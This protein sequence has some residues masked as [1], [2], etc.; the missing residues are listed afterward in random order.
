MIYLSIN[1]FPSIEIMNS[2]AE[3]GLIRV[4]VGIENNNKNVLK[5]FNKPILRSFDDIV[6]SIFTPLHISYHIGYMVFYP[7]VTF[8][9]IKESIN[10]LQ[11]I[12]KIHRVGVIL[13]KMRLIP[14]TK[15]C[16]KYANNEITGID[17]A[18]SY[19]FVDPKV[20]TLFVCL[21]LVFEYFLKS[22]HTKAEAMCTGYTLLDAFC[23]RDDIK[24]YTRRDFSEARLRH[25]ASI[26]DYQKCL[27]YFFDIFLEQ[28]EKQTIDEKSIFNCS[29]IEQF[30]VEFMKNVA[31]L[32]IAWTVLLN[33]VSD[34]YNFDAEKIVTWGEE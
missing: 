18:Y 15:M 3:A 20:N 5:T 17:G 4:F 26:G 25:E 28:I 32:Q 29:F 8:F 2:L 31:N 6:D 16:E 30:K 9:D 1:N 19:S 12:K 10:Y 27:S 34:I 14:L 13:E 24:K 33:T 7:E 22:W 23:Y 21:K 11:K